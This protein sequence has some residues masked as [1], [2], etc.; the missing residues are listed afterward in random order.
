MGVDI[1]ELVEVSGLLG[2]LLFGWEGMTDVLQWI[3]G[4]SRILGGPLREETRPFTERCSNVRLL[5]CLR[6]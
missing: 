3:C 4:Q 1:L 6:K 5:P 2:K